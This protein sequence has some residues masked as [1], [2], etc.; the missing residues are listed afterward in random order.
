MRDGV[1]FVVLD[2]DI[3][4]L[5]AHGLHQDRH[6]DHQLLAVLQH[7]AMVRS[8][9]GF[10]LHAVDDDALG[11]LTGRHRELHVRRERRSA[12]ADDTG[13]LDLGDDLLRREG[14]DLHQ[15]LRAVD[16]L[17]PLVALAL[18]R[19]HHLAQALAVGNHIHGRDR[20]RHRGV[21]VRR[22]EAAGFGDELSRQ[23][24]VALGDLGHGGSPD[25]LR[26]GNRHHL[27]QRQNLDRFGAA[28]LIFRRMDSAH[29]KCLHILFGSFLRF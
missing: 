29:W 21:N 8:E 28:Q 27:G 24:L 7:R 10:A 18:D 23:H 5:H 22:H 11:L 20:S 1:G 15:R 6:A 17:G 4:F 3:G 25:V 2:A 14:A 9:I 12:H 16:A 26:E 13:I 19:D